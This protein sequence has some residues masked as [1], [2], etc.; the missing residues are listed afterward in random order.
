MPTLIVG[1]NGDVN[2]LGWRIGVAECDDGNVDVARFLDRLRI[3]SRVGHDDQAWFLE[4]SGNIVGEATRREATGNSDCSSVGCKLKDG[5]LA[6]RSG[7]DNA[8]IG[9]IVDGDNDTGGENNLLPGVGL[10]L[11]S[12]AE[13]PREMDSRVRPKAYQVLP[14]WRT[15]TPS[16]RVF[17]R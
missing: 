7:G 8:N 6:V 10:A 3:G 14:I 4:G 1:W 15:F 13:K 12:P 17:Q 16:A 11:S 5:S 9:G 2:I